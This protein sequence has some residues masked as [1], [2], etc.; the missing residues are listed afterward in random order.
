[1]KNLFLLPFVCPF[2][3]LNAF[4]FQKENHS[5]EVKEDAAEMRKSP[6]SWYVSESKP[7][8]SLGK[9]EAAFDFHFTTAYSNVLLAVVT[10][11]NEKQDTLIPGNDGI[12]SL[13]LAPGKYLFRFFLN[14]YFFEITTDSVEIKP[15]YR[16]KMEIYFESTITPVISDKPVIYVYPE[17]TQA[18]QI[19]LDLEGK[20][21]F[22]YPAYNNGWSFT[23]DPDGTIHIGEKQYDYLFWDAHS[24]VNAAKIN[25][26]EG[27]V[28][29]RDS[30]PGFFEARLSQMGLNPREIEDYITYWCPRMNAN[31]ANYVHFAF[32]DEYSSFADLQV[33]PQPDHLFRVYM[34]W[35]DAA[36]KS[37][38][39]LKTQPL[40]SF[41]REGFSVVE[42][43]GSEMESLKSLVKE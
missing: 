9:S 19:R 14:E 20:L 27:F 6:V 11:Y 43:G 3:L 18:V 30:L 1:M 42:W 21:D 15:G 40:E 2:L 39:S 22:T 4:S 25:W 33:S 35:S 31:A 10:G 38:A 7:D 12:A 5:T 28:V 26:N 24:D 13:K 23:A 37:F 32:N 29:Q 36:G 41:K 34:F 17:K 16:S 8:S